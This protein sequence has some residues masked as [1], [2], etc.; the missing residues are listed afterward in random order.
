MENGMFKRKTDIDYQG[1]RLIPKYSQH[2][3]PPHFSLPATAFLNINLL[4]QSPI[5]R[6]KIYG[7]L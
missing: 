4:Q 1:Q 5:Y 7:A 3:D 6:Q 2:L